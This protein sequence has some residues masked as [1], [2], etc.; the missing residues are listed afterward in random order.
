MTTESNTRSVTTQR[1]RLATIVLAFAC[2]A[3]VLIA[4][5]SVRPTPIPNRDIDMGRLVRLTRTTDGN[6]SPAWSP[7]G[8]KIAFECFDHDWLKLLPDYRYQ[9]PGNTGEVRNSAI[10]F[11]IPS[12]ICV[13]NA[14]G[15]DQSQ[16]FDAS[17][18]Y[19]DIGAR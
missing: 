14:N 19:E 2:L 7:V 4:C 3:S 8:D 6:A 17:M 16:L 5:F 13:M 18:L 10:S 15:T 1:A 11:A 9:L 12:N